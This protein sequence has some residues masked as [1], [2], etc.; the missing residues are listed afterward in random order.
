MAS[1]VEVLTPTHL[2]RLRQ[3]IVAG[4]AQSGRERRQDSDKSRKHMV[5]RVSHVGDE[6][7][8]RLA[9]W[10]V[11]T[12]WFLCLSELKLPHPLTGKVHNTIAEDDVEI[13]LETGHCCPDRDGFALPV[14]RLGAGPQG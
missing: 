10:P 14:K 7:T 13:G 4:G 6:Y 2:G 9:S 8:Q 11:R 12:G 5:C 3:T 1:R